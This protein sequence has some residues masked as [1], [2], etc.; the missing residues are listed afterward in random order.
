MRLSPIWEYCA[1]PIVTRDMVEM[2]PTL[3]ERKQKQLAGKLSKN[4]YSDEVYMGFC[5]W[6]GNERER[7]A[8]V[9]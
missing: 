9:C 4:G 1:S 8:F 7:E 5:N 3:K 2:Y 6:A